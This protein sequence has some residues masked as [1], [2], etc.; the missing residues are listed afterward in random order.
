M[1]WAMLTIS[2]LEVDE[3]VCTKQCAL[4]VSIRDLAVMAVTLA[5]QGL[6]PVTGEQV[7]PPEVIRQV[8]AVMSTCGMWRLFGGCL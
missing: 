7:V 2:R 6:N 5:N 8:V 4:L 1:G 3:T